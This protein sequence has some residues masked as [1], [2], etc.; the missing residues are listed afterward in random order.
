MRTRRPLTSEVPITLPE[1]QHQ[2]LALKKVK[3]VN[4][5]P[6]REALELDE[7][8]WLENAMPIGD[9][10][11]PT[12]PQ[13]NTAT[14]TITGAVSIMHF[15]TLGTTNYHICFTTAGGAQSVN[16]ATGNVAQIFASGTF[17]D[18]SV[19]QWKSERVVIADP[20][21]YYSWDGSL[22][23]SPG[24]V[25]TISVVASG[26]VYTSTPVVVLTGGT[27]GT[28]ASAQAFLS[29]LGVSSISLVSLGSGYTSAPAVTF[30]GGTTATAGLATASAYIM[31][32]GQGGTAVSVYSG[33][34]WIAN[35]RTLTYTA[36][37]T[38]MD[39]ATADAAGSTTITEGFLR[40]SIQGLEA[41]DNYLYVFGDSAI[42]IIGDLKVTGA[43]TTF[44]LTNLSATTGT[45]LQN[46]ITAMERAI[47]FM[48]RYGVYA[49]FGASV[50][51]ISKALD[52]VFPRID[53]SQPVSA[54]LVQI[55][56]ILC[57]AVNFTYADT[58]GNRVIQAV[59][60]DG[61]WF[62]TS[63]GELDFVAPAQISGT[64]SLWGTTGS[65]IAQLYAN[66]TQTIAT[67]IQSGLYPLG[68]PIFD[69]QVIRAG[70]EYTAPAAST[71]ELQIDT[72]DESLTAQ[73]TASSEIVW[74]NDSG[75]EITWINDS[76]QEIT[77]NRSGYSMFN[78]PYP[79]VGKYIG[80]TI[81][82][83]SP[84]LVWNGT[85]FEYEQRSSW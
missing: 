75:T 36:P 51:K 81:T 28:T 37:N 42:F 60:F 31:P 8:A 64:L 52:G 2:Y 46:T 63:Q 85:L 20:S 35:N 6:S 55:Y 38:W 43:I 57:Y 68:N 54:G 29:G 56:N 45:T 26:S 59:F 50:T 4:T 82:S 1:T 34:V 39:F 53:F 5:Q 17:S 16:L 47:V 11:I 71:L 32:T 9:A 12:V 58:N 25:A 21:G 77:W 70:V 14:A 67:T 80:A 18:P 15:A 65:D 23:Y 74:Y 69:K 19:D 3:G 79:I 72:E 33:R 66:T 48:N 78:R 30:S 41:L 62:F 61:K 76:A 24:Q 7:F 13:V 40:Q 10:F 44:S 84:Q 83:N 49:L 22:S 73:A 27:A